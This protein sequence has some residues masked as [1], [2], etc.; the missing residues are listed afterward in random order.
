[1]GELYESRMHRAARDNYID[2]LREATRRECNAADED[3]LTPTLLAARYGNLEALRTL[4]G[5]G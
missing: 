5:R 1:M 4:V 3:G 2:L